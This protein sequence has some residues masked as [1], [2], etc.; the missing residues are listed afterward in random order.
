MKMINKLFKIMLIIV[1]IF[2]VVS[3]VNM[4]KVYAADGLTWESIT[5][6]AQKFIKKGKDNEQISP[7]EIEQDFIP[8]GQVLVI[9]ANAVVIVVIGVMGIRWITAK[10]EQQAKLKE[11]LIG[12]V[13]SVVVI[14]GA[15]V[16]WTVIKEFMEGIQIFN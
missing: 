12:L 3:H 6:K 4:E 2:I 5:D 15:V 14:Y 1:C 11:Q 16:I 9:A 13:V 10:P 7:S 8:V